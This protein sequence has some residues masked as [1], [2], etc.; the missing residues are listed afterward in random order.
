MPEGSEEERAEPAAL[1]ICRP[2]VTL[3]QELF[4]KCLGQI[5]GIMLAMAQLTRENEQR[6]PVSAAELFKSG[7]CFR[8]DRCQHHAPVSGAKSLSLDALG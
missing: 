3:F 2:N 4:E 7:R 1:R 6:F 5:L 8:P